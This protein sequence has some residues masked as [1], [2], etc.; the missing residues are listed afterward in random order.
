MVESPKVGASSGENHHWS[1]ASIVRVSPAQAF[2]TWDE[3]TAKECHNLND[4]PWTFGTLL[5]AFYPPFATEI[6]SPSRILFNKMTHW[7]SANQNLGSNTSYLTFSPIQ[8]I[9]CY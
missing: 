2:L 8:T 1:E 6:L 5:N 7:A 9:Y 4:A 3:S